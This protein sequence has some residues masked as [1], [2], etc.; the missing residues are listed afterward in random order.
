[1]S[2]EVKATSG[3]NAD[4]S[5]QQKENQ[6]NEESLEINRSAED[7]ARRLKETSAEAREWRKKNSELKLKLEEFEKS[8]LESEGKKDELIQRLKSEVSQSQEKLKKASEQFAYQVIA[9]KVVEAATKAGCQDTDAL[10][11]LAD[12]NTLEVDDNL[13]V[14]HESV[15]MMISDVQK[16]RPYLFKQEKPLPKDGVPL[17]KSTASLPEKLSID[18]LAN[19]IAELGRK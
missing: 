6:Q 17:G 2:N 12:V 4:A 11:K 15:K 13:N 19:K 3:Q 9:S 1:M 14:D 8:R 7:Y 18:D 16:Q 10:L 5:N